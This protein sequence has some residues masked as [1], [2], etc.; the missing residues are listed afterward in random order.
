M[1]DPTLLAPVPQATEPIDGH[2]SK[3]EGNWLRWFRDL[4]LRVEALPAESL[5]AAEVYTDAEVVTASA[6][7]EAYADAAV[8]AA[9]A[10]INATDD[11]IVTQANFGALTVNLGLSRNYRITLNANTTLTFSEVPGAGPFVLTLVQGGAG[12]FTCAITGALY[13][14]GVAPVLATAAGTIHRLIVTKS[15]SNYLV[16]A[17]LSFA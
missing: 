10:A 9:V 2:T 11:E 5:A 14:G 6:A 1:P 7:L 3:M 16:V 4:K 8:A 13:P 17:S 12:G 15:G